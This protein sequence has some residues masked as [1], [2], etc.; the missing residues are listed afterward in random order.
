[1]AFTDAQ[2]ANQMRELLVSKFCI[3]PIQWNTLFNNST[4]VDVRRVLRY[5]LTKDNF[6]SY[7]I[8]LRNWVA[9]QGGDIWT[10]NGRTVQGRVGDPPVGHERPLYNDAFSDVCKTVLSPKFLLAKAISNQIRF[11]CFIV[12]DDE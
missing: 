5:Q 10:T 12:I 6:D 2:L 4:E 9:A 1:M 7:W 11:I 8:A 3:N